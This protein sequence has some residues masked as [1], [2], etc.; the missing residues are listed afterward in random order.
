LSRLPARSHALAVSSGI[1]LV[2][3]LS[4]GTLL[5]WLGYYWDDWLV[6]T[7]DHLDLHIVEQ[8]F[9]PVLWAVRAAT[10]GL[11]GVR[12]LSWHLLALLARGLV[13]LAF[14]WTCSGLWP[15][16]RFEVA[17]AS[18]LFAVYP[19]FSGQP[20][21]AI[22][23]HIL[24][25]FAIHLASF[26]VMIRAV[27]RSRF[28]LPMAGL[29]VALCALSFLLS[30]YFMGL[31]LLRPV[32]LY[33][34]M[35]RPRARAVLRWWS[36]YVAL[37][38]VYL[39][40]RIAFLHAPERYDMSSVLADALRH[41]FLVLAIRVRIV[42]ADLV[43]LGPM[44][45][46][47]LL[48][49]DLLPNDWG[50]QRAVPFSWV[51]SVATAIVAGAVLRSH[52]SRDAE[53][54]DAGIAWGREACFLGL[55]ASCLGQ[56]PFWLA[57]R[58]IQ[59]GTLFDRYALPAAVGSSLLAAGLIFLLLRTRPQQIACAAI[60][61]GLAA[62][63]HVRNANH[64]RLDWA[65]QKT[66]FWQLSWRIPNLTCGARLLVPADDGAMDYTADHGLSVPVNWMFPH[67]AGV[68]DIRVRTVRSAAA[69]AGLAG[70]RDNLAIAFRPPACLRVLR[71]DEPDWPS[72]SPLD[73]ATASYS[74]PA[75]VDL[76]DAGR[77]AVPTE[78]F[79]DEPVHDVC[80]QIL[81]AEARR[82]RGQ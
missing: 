62:G 35:E 33:L 63:L 30:E 54:V 77:A 73:R 9:R 46:A 1:L 20:L 42:L 68:C 64:Y 18:F 36:P 80:F 23:S 31:E 59:L 60:L 19:G 32:L 82:D 5:P 17:V 47:R 72:L 81:R 7:Q 29:A 75:L 53:T 67:R 78:V 37:L 26:A 41:P 27:R 8:Q 58:E 56:L 71:P 39:V 70:S 34:A 61:V 21:A 16:R 65:A 10:L 74:N 48:G 4:Y 6:F 14:W 40:W 38:A 49:S 57:G 12:P 76:R 51:V 2:V 55:A 25:Q 15:G 24:L 13:A 50:S 52:R 45:W 28:Q 66:L 43:R 44:A 22:Y 79:G 11:L 3:A 69:L